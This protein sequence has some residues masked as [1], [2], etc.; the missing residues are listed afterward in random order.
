MRR[1]PPLLAVPRTHP[2]HRQEI[3]LL[4]SSVSILFY[5]FTFFFHVRTRTLLIYEKRALL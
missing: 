1:S 5:L 4:P 2:L 3:D